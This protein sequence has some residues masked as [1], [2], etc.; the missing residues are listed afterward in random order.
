M[1]TSDESSLDS[2][3]SSIN[4]SIDNSSNSHHSISSLQFVLNCFF[5]I[6][7]LFSFLILLFIIII[8][9]L[10]QSAFKHELGNIINDSIDSAMPI[11]INLDTID[12]VQLDAIL[13]M[14][15][16]YSSFPF[17]K[18]IFKS[19]I[20]QLYDTFKS[21]PYILNNYIKEYSS[22]NYLIQKHND[23]IISFGI[24]IVIALYVITIILC[25]TFKYYYPDSINLSK[26]LIE[27]LLTFIIIGA[28]EYWFFMTYA[29]N[30]IP[31]PPSLLSKSAIDNVKNMLIK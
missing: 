26:L 18:T 13:S 16:I 15:P 25:I 22:V 7:L 21:N 30:F 24:S 11:P 23:D 4:S 9:P 1:D 19:N 10:A 5:H 6:S 28:G 14:L 31:A 29:K 20:R 17:S 2:I 3:N 27:N 8:G 12:D